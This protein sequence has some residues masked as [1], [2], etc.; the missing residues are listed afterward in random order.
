MVV[1]LEKG[2]KRKGRG[3]ERQLPESSSVGVVV[4]HESATTVPLSTGMLITSN[5][6]LPCDLNPFQ[7]TV[8]QS[9]NIEEEITNQYNDQIS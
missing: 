2:S 5:P 3:R 8:K 1:W 7:E 4:R 6:T 9:C